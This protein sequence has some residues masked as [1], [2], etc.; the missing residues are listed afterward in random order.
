VEA[1]DSTEAKALGEKTMQVAVESVIADKTPAGQRAAMPTPQARPA[2][3][4]AAPAPGGVEADE[5]EA[6]NTRRT[7]MLIGAGVAVVLLIVA[8]FLLFPAHRMP[9]KPPEGPA[10]RPGPL[11]SLDRSQQGQE[12]RNDAVQDVI[13]R[14]LWT[15][16]VPGAQNPQ[17]WIADEFLTL[18]PDQKA[19]L[20]NL[21]YQWNCVE[22][23]PFGESDGDAVDI[24]SESTRGRIGTFAPRAGGL[25]IE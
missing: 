7:R 17:I 24:Y 19:G 11:G 9:E 21:F 6:Q 20:C 5:G 23:P 25:K 12:R 10:T 1:Q 22:N 14:G 8:Y 16:V 15:R 3:A 13:K 18:P 4:V 2:A